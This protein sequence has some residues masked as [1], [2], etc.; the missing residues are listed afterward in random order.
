MNSFSL[1]L[2]KMGNYTS[3]ELHFEKALDQ[4]K[5]LQDNSARDA[6][7]QVN[8]DVPSLLYCLCSSIAYAAAF[9]PPP[10]EH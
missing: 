7:Q 3:S 9:L 8:T 1:F 2:V 10:P 6:I 5:I 4:A